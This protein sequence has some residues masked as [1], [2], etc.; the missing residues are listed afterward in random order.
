MARPTKLTPE[1][2]EQIL[3]AYRAG[4]SKEHAAAY[5]GVSHT[6]L[7]E[8]QARGETEAQRREAGEDPIDNESKFV[9]FAEALRKA[10]S[11]LVVRNLALIQRAAAREDGSWQAAAWLLE[12]KHPTLFG[13]KFVQAEVSGPNGAPLQVESVSPGDLESKIRRVMESRG[14]ASSTQSDDDV[15]EDAG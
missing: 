10:E 1:V 5:A 15:V 2:Q 11:D 7:F 4:C 13:R 3:T 12:R 6:A 14:L 8:W 9:A